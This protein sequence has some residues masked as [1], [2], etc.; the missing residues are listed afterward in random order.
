MGAIDRHNAPGWA[1]PPLNIVQAAEA[2][3]ISRSTLDQALKNKGIR[4]GVHFELRGNRKVFYRENIL[5]MRKVL[6]ECAC[7]S[8]G[9]MDGPMPTAPD[10]MASES[11]ALLRLRTLAAQKNSGRT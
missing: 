6:T 8:N 2:L 1:A 9:K 11:D 4:P 7:R 10:P 3:G 5:E